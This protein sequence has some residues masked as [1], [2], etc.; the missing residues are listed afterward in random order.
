MSKKL[1]SHVAVE[2]EDAGPT[3]TMPLNIYQIRMPPLTSRMRCVDVDGCSC[4]PDQAT[5]RPSQIPLCGEL[6]CRACTLAGTLGGLD[7][8][9][10]LNSQKISISCRS[11]TFRGQ[12][13]KRSIVGISEPGDLEHDFV[14]TRGLVTMHPQ[15]FEFN[16]C[17]KYW[18][19]MILRILCLPQL[20][21][22]KVPLGTASDIVSLG[23]ALG[24]MSSL[25]SLT[26]TDMPDNPD[27]LNLLPIL[28]L[29]ILSRSGTLRELGLFLTN[30]NR[31]DQYCE[32]WER[33]E[34]ANEAFVKPNSYDHFFEYIFPSSPDNV[35][36]P[37]LQEYT[38]FKNAIS[39]SPS[40]SR[41]RTLP[42]LKLR[43]LCLK[44][45]DLPFDAFTRVFD[46][47]RLEEFHLRYCDI[48]RTVWAC[49][50]DSK[51]VALESVD[52]ELLP[53]IC[54]LLGTKTSLESLSFDRPPDI[55]EDGDI[56]WWSQDEA[57]THVL[58]A[59]SQPPPLGQST[60]W[61]RRSCYSQSK[62]VDFPS[63][64]V[65]MEKLT[66]T[67]VRSFLLPADMYDI[68]PEFFCHLGF[69]L[70]FLQHLTCGFDYSNQVSFCLEESFRKLEITT[71]KRLTGSPQSFCWIL[72]SAREIST[73]NHISF[74]SSPAR[75][76]QHRELA[77]GLRCPFLPSFHQGSWSEG[78]KHATL[79]T[80]STPCTKIKSWRT[81]KND[82]ILSS[83]RVE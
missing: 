77:P 27:Y 20:V 57:P 29:G 32:T 44:R 22:L 69:Q 70:P 56:I 80:V 64:E 24:W 45:I 54:Q 30:F 4:E 82:G 25:Q 16:M 62:S 73:K 63:L 59:R 71:N 67:R 41:K 40:C 15:C 28:G 61:C 66:R 49:L 2:F 60:E 21:T 5:R 38:T 10:S 8:Y 46:P 7:H 36:E 51:L 78:P 43:K 6:R 47:T 48:D 55:Y 83:S 37:L 23:K 76:E 13:G 58:Q 39:I 35:S 50:R 72:S 31:P 68:T 26:V 14:G 3:I 17:W 33:N 18:D 53:S 9:L 81:T 19:F 65:L 12:F 1:L 42:L 52:Y 79:H 11:L 74:A 75:M 34:M